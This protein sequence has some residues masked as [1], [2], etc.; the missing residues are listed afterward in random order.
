[1]AKEMT[2]KM[3]DCEFNLAIHA[4]EAA[5]SDAAEAWLDKALSRG[6]A[7]SVHQADAVTGKPGPSIGTML[8]V[9]GNAWIRFTDKRDNFYKYV[10]RVSRDNYH[11]S[12][13]LLYK[14]AARQEMGLHEAAIRAAMDVLKSRGIKNIQFYSY[15]D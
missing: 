11:N 5:A 4:A 15:I 10:K 3:K 13:P 6:P 9:C 14:H 8:D 2:V 1:M 12:V 7:F